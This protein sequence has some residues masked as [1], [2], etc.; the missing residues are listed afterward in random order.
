MRCACPFCGDFMPQAQN[1]ARCVCPHCGYVCAACIYRDT[2]LDLDTIRQM[3]EDK[4]FEPA[5][6]PDLTG[7][8]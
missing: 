4:V 6:P 5:E 7:E 3:A 1:Q 8:S 2:P